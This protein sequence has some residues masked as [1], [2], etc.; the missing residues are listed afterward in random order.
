MQKKL[1]RFFANRK[2]PNK[3]IKIGNPDKIRQNNGILMISNI[4]PPLAYWIKY[5]LSGKFSVKPWSFVFFVLLQVRS[6]T[7]YIHS[8]IHFH[9]KQWQTAAATAAAAAL[10][11]GWGAFLGYQSCSGYVSGMPE[12]MS[13][14]LDEGWNTFS[15]YLS[16]VFFCDCFSETVTI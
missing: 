9:V 5:I 8:F 10:G 2:F 13:E 7:S 6:R 11:E 1:L 4:F 12:V 3:K 16:F 14:I 15:F